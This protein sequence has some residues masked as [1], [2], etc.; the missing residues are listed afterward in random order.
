MDTGKDITL[1]IG[2]CLS[3]LPTIPDSSIDAIISDPPYPEIKR[4]YGKISESDWF[5]LMKEVIHQSKRIL[6]PTGSAV[7]ILQP[8]SKKIGSMRGWLWEFMAWVCRE[9]NIVQDVYWWNLSTMPQEKRGLTRSSLKTCL[10]VGEPNC[11]R[12][13]DK[14]LWQESQRNAEV[15]MAARFKN[16]EDKINYR[17]GDVHFR[18]L[19][20]ASKAEERGGVTPFNVL[21]IANS[22]SVGSAGAY[23]HGAGTPLALAD[24][25]TRYVCPPNGIILDPFCGSG[26]MGVAAINNH[27]GFIGIDKMSK[28]IDIAKDR[29]GYA[30]EMKYGHS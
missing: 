23:G 26:T 13:Q 1:H 17:P 25:W 3:I 19:R 14:V 21:P 18:E 6:K 29:M 12:A 24:W 10:W 4:E 11:Y 28:Y 8:N 20:T 2:D 15:R 7:F 30:L 16:A 22:V 9:W 27:C 5:D